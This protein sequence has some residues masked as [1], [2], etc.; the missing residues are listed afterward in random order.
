M[1]KPH[2]FIL[3]LAIAM[4]F[5]TGCSPK[6]PPSGAEAARVFTDAL[7][8]EVRVTGCDRVV[9]AS[10]SFAQLWLL[11]GGAL[12]GTTD[13]AFKNFEGIPE[14]AA[15]VGSLMAPGFEAILALDPDLVILSADISGQTDL[16]E[17]LRS[18]KITAAY[19]SV[20]S[21]D[22]YL[23]MLKIC[24]DITGRGDLYEQN[25]LR[26]RS[27]I[28]GIVAR[29]KDKPSPKILFI[30][31]GAGKVT[32]RNSDTMAGAM[33]RDMGCVN[34]ADSETGLLDRLSM[35][36]IIKE[37]PDFIFVATQGDSEEEAQ[38]T[39]RETLTSNPAWGGLSAVKNNRYV[40]LPK[41]LF[42]LKPNNR[43]DEAYQALW[44]VLYG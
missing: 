43:W 4:A 3:M 7:G 20:E 40:S 39:L 28:D 37:D 38:E 36:V 42:Q 31:A 8:R 16:A 6:A 44:D 25:G 41:E 1:K 23:D 18:A 13:D 14:S 15:S 17:P 19:F 29:T 27:A 30:R 33:L 2:V 32:A 9:V 24:T 22:E 12:A 35:E 10:G 26:L 21:F 11:S 34:I 5:T